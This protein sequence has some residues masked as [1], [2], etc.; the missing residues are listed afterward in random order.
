M[1]LGSVTSSISLVRS[2]QYGTVPATLVVLKLELGA[3]PG[4]RHRFKSA[5]LLVK[6]KSLS[7]PSLSVLK[8]WP[9]SFHDTSSTMTTEQK[10][11][12]G[13]ILGASQAGVAVQST[14]ERSSSHIKQ[15]QRKITGA[16]WGKPLRNQ[17]QWALEE[18]NAQK[19]GIWQHFQVA[20]LV[21]HEGP[22]SLEMGVKVKVG[23]TADL[24]KF[25]LRPLKGHSG[26]RII[27]PTRDIGH[28]SALADDADFR[29]VDIAS[30]TTFN[31]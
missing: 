12:G 25:L 29:D 2:G 23:F 10:V 11:S 14:F 17:V 13:G 27:D 6:L 19:N 1:V 4:N 9:E 24:R 3:P 21:K 26:A 31:T 15:H 18:N 16:S 8:Y 5:S 28:T 20:L 30:F 7:T 22:F